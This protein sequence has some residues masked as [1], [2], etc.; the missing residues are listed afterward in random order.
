MVK[1]LLGDHET[2]IVHLRKDVDTSTDVNKDAGTA[3]SDWLDGSTRNNGMDTKKI[4]RIIIKL[5]GKFN[6]R[7][8]Y[9]FQKLLQSR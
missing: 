6:K 4:F 2:I 1:E 5:Y 9:C 7:S 3:D 8:M